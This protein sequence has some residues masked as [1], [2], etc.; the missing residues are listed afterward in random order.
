MGFAFI[1][2]KE[3]D[4]LL[5]FVPSSIG[6]AVIVTDL[7][8]NILFMN[9]MAE[10]LTGYSE[11][12][13]YGKTIFKAFDMFSGEHGKLLEV[14]KKTNE[15]VTFGVEHR[16]S[17]IT[18][19]SEKLA[20]SGSI[21]PV[22]NDNDE[23]IGL[24]IIIYNLTIQNQ[25]KKQLEY[26]STH[27]SLT[28]SYNRTWF[29]YECFRNE[30]EFQTPVGLL[31]CDVDGLKMINDTMGHKTGDQALITTVKILKECIP[32][33]GMIARVGGDE[34]V[35]LLPRSSVEAVRTICKRINQKISEYNEMNAEIPLSISLGFSVSNCSSVNISKLFQEA[36]NNMYKEKLH[37]KKSFRNTIINTILQV[38][39]ARDHITENHSERLSSLVELLALSLGFP[40][41]R[42]NDLRLLAKFHDIGKVGIPDGILLKQGALTHDEMENMQR[43]CEIGHHI[44][45]SSPDL[46]HIAH[47]ILK[48]H[49]WWNGNG[50]PLGLKG[51]NIPIECRILSIV[52]AYDAMTHDR[53]YRKAMSKQEALSELTK[54]AGIQFDPTMVFEFISALKALKIYVA[55][56]MKDVMLSIKQAY[57]G[58]NSPKSLFFQS[59]GSGTLMRQIER[60]ALVD[61]FISAGA[62]QMDELQMRGLIINDSRK[63]FLR[64]KIVLVTSKDSN[65]TCGFAE[66]TE[67]KIKKIGIGN[68]DTVPAGKY[69]QEVLMSFGI[70]ESVRSKLVLAKDVRQVL[71]CVETGCVD[72]GI[73]YQ[74]DAIIS[75]NVKILSRAP[76]ISH[77]P[78]VYSV[79]IVKDT[80]NQAE[81]ENFIKFLIKNK[82]AKEI[83][84]KYGFVLP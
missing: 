54:F 9:C 26:I 34:F 75:D 13:A 24:V 30:A 46:S 20:I 62:S 25:I 74:T 49:E 52:D 42:I 84:Q 81:S 47:W 6:E 83:F 7:C 78:V 39:E 27:D 18:K 57:I 80:D 22:K 1:R 82:R 70:L 48:H 71:N 56:S 29:E 51:E 4:N 53:P 10:K 28:G 37:H 63:D 3:I 55:S 38:A 50:Y 2:K 41:D 45:A 8:T 5:Y 72:V 17:L 36:D 65:I 31:M 15:I 67:K 58:D 61:I 77:S 69:A 79:A 43:H 32:E 33:R 16:V 76:E 12:E 21:S 66:L 14:S 59:G 44:A 23:I 68:P 64:N 35:V 40:E 73:V 19:K 11:A 60:K